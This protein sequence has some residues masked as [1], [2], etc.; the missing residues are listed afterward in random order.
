M[1]IWAL[2]M[3]LYVGGVPTEYVIDHAT[4]PGACVAMLQRTQNK[5][6][7][8]VPASIRRDV[9]RNGGTIAR[10]EFACEKTRVIPRSNANR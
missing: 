3:T 7:Y 9:N 5:P 1:T 8:R 2:V 6:L 4:T 10:I